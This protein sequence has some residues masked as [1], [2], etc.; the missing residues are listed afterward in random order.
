MAND[1]AGKDLNA[2]KNFWQNVPEGPTRDS[3]MEGLVSAM[4]EK[5][6]P[7]AASYISGL[8]SLEQNRAIGTLISRW[9]ADDPESAAN[10]VANLNN[11]NAQAS[12]YQDL[13]LGWAH[14]DPA[15]AS[16][17]L[18]GLPE[19]KTRQNL[20]Q[21]FV[22]YLG[23]DRPELAAPWATSLADADER[24]KAIQQVAASWLQTDADSAKAWLA[25]TSLP[26]ALKQML[27]NH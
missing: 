11:P 3:F 9:S 2:A 17:W 15:R 20:A 8:P 18:S 6:V 5:S 16:E 1:W 19:N 14:S 23:Y 22:A 4:V 27:L 21:T 13:L 12:A 26:D 24:N 25:T 10:W 7:D